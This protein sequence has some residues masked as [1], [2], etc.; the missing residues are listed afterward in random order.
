MS[1]LLA[2]MNCEI[3]ITDTIKFKENIGITGYGMA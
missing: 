1:H 3:I 2:I